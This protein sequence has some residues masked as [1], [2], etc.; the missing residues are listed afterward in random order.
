MFAYTRLLH[1]RVH[2]HD[3]LV[4]ETINSTNMAALSDAFVLDAGWHHM[5]VTATTP[6][7]W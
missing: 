4:F 3:R 7:E 1:P 5:A 2:A 6:G